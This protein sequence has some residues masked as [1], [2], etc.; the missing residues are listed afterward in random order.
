M[1]TIEDFQKNLSRRP[2][3]ELIAS[4]FQEDIPF[5]GSIL[6]TG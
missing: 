2:L 1:P 3:V 5:D 6:N 4:T